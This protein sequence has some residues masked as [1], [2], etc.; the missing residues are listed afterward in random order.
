M[1]EGGAD[2]FTTTTVSDGEGDYGG[3]AGTSA[4]ASQGRDGNTERRGG[5][6]SSFF[7][8]SYSRQATTDTTFTLAPSVSDGSVEITPQ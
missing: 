3:A 8:D 5:G 4:S 2:A 1:G 7:V 6:G